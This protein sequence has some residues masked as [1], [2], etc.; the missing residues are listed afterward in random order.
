[1]A[2]DVALRSSGCEAIVEGFYVFANVQ[3]KSRGQ[4][5]D[6]LVQRALVDWTLPHFRFKSDI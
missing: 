5:N 4:S 1:M 6:I 3:K 2:L